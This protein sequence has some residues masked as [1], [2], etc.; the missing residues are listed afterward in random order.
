MAE[1]VRA[2]AE[3][4]TVRTNANASADFIGRF[5][6]GMPGILGGSWEA[7]KRGALSIRRQRM[8][9]MSRFARDASNESA[10]T[11]SPRCTNSRPSL[12]HQ[13]TFVH[14][15]RAWAC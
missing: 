13:E 7:H 14:R 15:S 6:M 10:T 4:A 5:P 2:D 9:L 8:V 1:G 11:R 3:V 12:N